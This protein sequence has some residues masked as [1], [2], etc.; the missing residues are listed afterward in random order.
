MFGYDGNLR[1]K[2]CDLWLDSRA[3]KP[4]GFISH[5][6]SDHLA[7]HQLLLAT[8]ETLRLCEHRLGKR[9]GQVLPYRQPVPLGDVELTT[10]P[11]GHV[12]GSAMLHARTPEGSLLYTGDFRLRPART[13]PPAEAPQADV[14]IM[15]C[16]YGKPRYRFPDRQ[17]VQEDFVALVRDSL[18][19][20]VTPLVFVYT[21]GKA[22]EATRILTDAS[23]PVMVHDSIFAINRLYEDLGMPLGPYQRWQ[24]GNLA[25]H[26]CLL[27]VNARFVRGWRRVGP[28][29]TIQLSGWAIDSRYGWRMGVD[30]AFPLSDHADFGELLELVE[31]VN[32]RQVY[33]THGPE[34][35]AK[36]LQAAGWSA[37]HLGAEV[38]QPLLF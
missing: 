31:R 17:G 19:A 12:L 1:L 25:G 35:F 22:Q 14:L 34:E 29:I 18:D 38:Y 21:L 8:P 37:A 9:T 13:C 5:A 33:C 15:E 10:F 4:I 26:A 20:G 3:A 24:P 2:S 27:P 28:R 36:S 16:T 32:P 23:V 7:R 11:A 6:H 30:H